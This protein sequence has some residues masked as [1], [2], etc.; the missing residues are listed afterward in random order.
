MT[1]LFEE[2]GE[3][4]HSLALAHRTQQISQQDLMTLVRGEVALSITEMKDKTE[5]LIRRFNE[6]IGEAIERGET[7]RMDSLA[8][9][10]A[11]LHQVMGST[12]IELR[13]G[14]SSV[15]LAFVSLSSLL[16]PSI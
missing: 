16:P 13:K 6:K 3:L 9:F 8:L 4:S 7:E 12:L 15:Q 5:D 14:I 1:S 10:D 2:L 11:Q